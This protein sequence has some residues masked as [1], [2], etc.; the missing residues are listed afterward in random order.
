MLSV[1][2]LLRAFVVKEF[3]FFNT[4]ISV[5]PLYP[6]KKVVQT[7]PNRSQI[8]AKAEIQ[9]SKFSIQHSKF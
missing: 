2:V 1:F 5:N 9:H 3:L 4:R 7:P 6:L 8:P